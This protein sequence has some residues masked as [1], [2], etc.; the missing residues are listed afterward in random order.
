[1]KNETE[2]ELPIRD[3]HLPD[4]VDWWPIAPG[5]WLL[6]L[7]TLFAILLVYKKFKK[8]SNNQTPE[9]EKN[10]KTITNALNL[11]NE[12]NSIDNNKQAIIKISILLRRTAMSLYG[13]ENVAGLTGAQ[14]LNFLDN[15]GATTDFSDG[16]GQVLI[17]QPYKKL[18]HYNRKQVVSITKQWLQAQVKSS[19]DNN[20]EGAKGT[21]CTKRLSRA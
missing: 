2:N 20:L 18:T 12:I 1:M 10:N 9:S 7:L 14:W 15:K 16:S 3:I 13:R 21:K 5:W 6:F 11:L 8:S 19:D 4:N 17:Q